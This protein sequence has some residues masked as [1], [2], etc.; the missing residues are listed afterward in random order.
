MSSQQ[1]TRLD[2]EQ[3]KKGKT[4]FATDWAVRNKTAVYLITLFV[5]IWGISLFVN[6]P[7]EQFPDV[8]IPT[9]YVQTVYVGNSPKDMENLVT[10]PIEKQLRGI[11]G[12]GRDVHRDDIQAWKDSHH[13][14]SHAG[15][16]V[17]DH[18]SHAVVPCSDG[19]CARALVRTR[20][21]DCQPNQP[22]ARAARYPSK[23]A[24]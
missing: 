20:T 21:A 16:H 13:V 19:R 6:L 12:V 23:L 18:L 17:L 14:A 4:F 7:K 10:R 15:V 24:N 8:V 22:G 2:P 11:T 3:L 1:H 5:S 9:I